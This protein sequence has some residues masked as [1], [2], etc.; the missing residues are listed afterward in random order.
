MLC[1]SR[2]TWLL[3]FLFVAASAA[4]ADPA[5]DSAVTYDQVRPVFRKHCVTC[6]NS[7]R[8]RGDLDLSSFGAIK[9]GSGSGPVAIAAKPDE[10]LLYTVTAHLEEPSMPPNKPKIPQREIDLIRRWIDGGMPERGG[11]GASP[12]R[13][14]ASPGVA[15]ASTT[16]TASAPLLTA[17]APLP[18]PTAATALA[19]SPAAPLVAVS[20]LRQVVLFSLESRKPLKAFPFPEGDVFSLTFSRDG[21]LLLIG[22]GIGGLSGKVVC[23][24]VA[25][26]QR[27][28]DLGDESDAVLAADMT[29][30]RRLV[31]LGGP[32][33]TVK[34]FRTADGQQTAT[35]RKHTDWIL[36]VAFS[37]DGLLL[38]S[39]DRFGGVQVWEAE[40][41]KEFYTLRGHS[42]PVNALR[43]ATDGQRLL[44]G[45]QDGTARWWDLH[46][47][48]QVAEW[49]AQKG[50]VLDLALLP[51]NKVLAGGRAKS[52]IRWD[53]PETNSASTPLGDEIVK[54]A[55]T[56]DGST[57]VAALING[58]I[59]VVSQPDGKL[60]GSLSLPVDASLIRQS[61]PIERTPARS[62]NPEL[63]ASEAVA[64]R[65]A[66][67]LSV[68]Q[69]AVAAAESAATSVEEAA[70]RARDAAIKLKALLGRQEAAA[71]QAASRVDELRGRSASGK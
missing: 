4:A 57:V 35:L 50:G 24:E 52:L 65:M 11:E 47:G 30:D 43:W 44:S 16:L 3:M 10:S 32:G 42:G 5:T 54:L 56:S 27:V 36:S 9:S 63:A 46:R 37:P 26:G 28:F 8:P 14:D 2:P 62:A 15:V 21:E 58:E 40:S 7:D 45:G 31:A 13:P 51:E 68:T 69:E 29:A 48:K 19:I 33:R 66:A 53:A 71:R 55:A 34:V 25:S 64:R 23:V 1:L 6:H 70:T 59:V 22:G 18:R 20:G 17:V 49:S 67:E 12:G 39:G 38:A 41:G 60:V 61:R